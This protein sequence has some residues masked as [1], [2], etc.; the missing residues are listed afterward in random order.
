VDLSDARADGGAGRG[1]REPDPGAGGVAGGEGRGGAAALD[2]ERRGRR[3]RG[4]GGGGD[5]E[6]AGRGVQVLGG[7]LDYPP[8]RESLYT[9]ARG[10]NDF[11]PEHMLH[12]TESALAEVGKTLAGSKVALLG[13]A[14]IND[15]DD[16][17]NTPA[18]PFRDAA[19]A[20]GAEVAVHDPWVD[21]A[22]SPDAPPGL[23]HDL[24]GVLSGADA[25]VVF[26]GHKEYR[27]LSPAR[28]KEVSGVSPP[29]GRGW[30]QRRGPGRVDRSGVCL[31]R[32]RPGR[33]EQAYTTISPHPHFHT[34]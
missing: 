18:E 25:V 13:W 6:G 23:S 29:G 34:V 32:D 1:V 19:I 28:V 16:A 11:M 30:A 10:I 15:S 31:P 17:R 2:G 5:C 27:G 7:E 8:G 9:L 21:P 20:A 26:A 14:F 22:T 33:Q 12:L 3:G 24:A 4:R